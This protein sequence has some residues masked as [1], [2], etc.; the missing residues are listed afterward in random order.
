MYTVAVRRHFVAKHY[1]IGGD[2]GNENELHSHSYVIEVS[3][4]GACLNEHGYLVDIMDIEAGL[5]EL[6]KRIEDRT[7]NDFPEFSG[8]NPSLER[9]ANLCCQGMVEGL[10]NPPVTA[11]CV[12]IFENDSAWASCCLDVL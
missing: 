6:I 5:T 12:K 8:L 1:L 3:L 2:W 11:V 7:L 4:E 9:L 10:R